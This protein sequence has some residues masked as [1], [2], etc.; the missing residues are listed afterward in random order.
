MLVLRTKHTGTHYGQSG[1]APAVA[2]TPL[3]KTK[4]QRTEANWK[5]SRSRTDDSVRLSTMDSLSN[6]SE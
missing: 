1:T 2:Y 4:K 5:I 6:Q 3:K